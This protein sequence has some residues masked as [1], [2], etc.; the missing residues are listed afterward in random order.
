MSILNENIDNEYKLLQNDFRAGIADGYSYD[1]KI[2]K[3]INTAITFT[4]NNLNSLKYLEFRLINNRNGMIYDLNTVNNIDM[5]SKYE[6]ENYTL[7]IGNLD[8][9]K[10]EIS[11]FIP[12]GYELFQNYPN[13]FN[14]Q[15][16]I[17]Y[18]IPKSSKVILKIYDILGKEMVQLVNEIKHA[19][20]HSV[21]FDASTLSSGIYFYRLQ[22]G[23]FIDT[24]KFL[25]LK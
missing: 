13:P 24:K 17:S 25:L 5:K 22:A 4:H 15:T 10:N 3:P 12:T 18:S 7:L 14:P 19:G 11:E 21:D 23:D 2:K 9:V 8:Y 6:N 16:T 1:I 20:N